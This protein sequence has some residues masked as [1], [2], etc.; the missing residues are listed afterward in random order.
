M[1]T[2]LNQLAR[3]AFLLFALAATGCVTKSPRWSS[4]PPA[5]RAD[6]KPPPLRVP[7]PIRL[8][9]LMPEAQA[10]PAVL[11]GK[12]QDVVSGDYSYA[13]L[14]ALLRLI[15]RVEG[16][17]HEVFAIR[18]FER[19]A[20]SVELHGHIFNCAVSPEGEWQ[21]VGMSLFTADYFGLPNPKP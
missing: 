14:Q 21:I 5:Q 19:F 2:P 16:V 8:W 10:T 20:A 11:M 12:K 6:V 15:G 17:R 7:E 4:A 1:A 13:S 18:F 9:K 3:I